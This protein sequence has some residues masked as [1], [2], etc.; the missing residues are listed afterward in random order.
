MSNVRYEVGIIC[1][2]QVEEAE[3]REILRGFNP[4]T[5]RA[6]EGQINSY[7]AIKT[8]WSAVFKSESDSE[9]CA[10]AILAK[11]KIPVLQTTTLINNE[12]TS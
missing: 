5:I 4:E 10:R 6:W 9:S 11:G 2:D 7:S 8:V 3:A 1:D 12:I